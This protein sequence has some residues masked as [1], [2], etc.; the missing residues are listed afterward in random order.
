MKHVSTISDLRTLQMWGIRIRG[1][2]SNPLPLHS[3]MCVLIMGQESLP[4]LLSDPFLQPLKRGCQKLQLCLMSPIGHPLPTSINSFFMS[5][6]FLCLFPPKYV[7]LRFLMVW[8]IFWAGKCSEKTRRRI[9]TWP[10]LNLSPLRESSG[11]P[12]SATCSWACP[13]TV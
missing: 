12:Q 2:V 7:S 6:L 13:S 11:L 3:Q 9:S 1:A 8:P 4:R 5:K 10:L